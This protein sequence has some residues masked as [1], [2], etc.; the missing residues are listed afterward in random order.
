MNGFN[1][2]FIDDHYDYHTA[3]DSYVEG[4]QKYI[5]ASGS[6]SHAITGLS[7]LCHNF[8]EKISKR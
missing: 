3:Q 7:C 6:L 5:G 2:A 4:G 1:F 8:H